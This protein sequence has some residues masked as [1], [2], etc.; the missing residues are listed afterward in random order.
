MMMCIL[1]AFPYIM[2]LNIR[3]TEDCLKINLRVLM[4]LMTFLREGPQFVLFFF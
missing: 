4:I 3:P 1:I 2:A